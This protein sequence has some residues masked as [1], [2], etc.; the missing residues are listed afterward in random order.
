[1]STFPWQLISIDILGPL[2]R[3]MQGHCYILMVC[4]WFSK[5]ILLHPLRK[6]NSKSIIKFVE[7]NVFLMFGV[8]QII[9][10]DNGTQ[11]VSRDFQKLAD[12][13]K[14]KIWY[15]AKYHPQTNSVERVNR[16]AGAAIRSYIK[17]NNHRY[18][19]V[20][21]PKIGF[22]LR[23][24]IH[25]A[26]G[27]SPTYINFGRYVPISGDFYDRNSDPSKVD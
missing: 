18:W 14:C 17:D 24:A 5:F 13:Y 21:L 23:T 20:H 1:M 9:T 2:P 19:D 15:N 22:A 7:E 8:P 11:F 26:T 6:A 27:L 4:D 16:V 10:C 25:E 12:L 3:S